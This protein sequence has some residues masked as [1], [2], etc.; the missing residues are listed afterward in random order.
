MD[1]IKFHTCV[2]I[3]GPYYRVSKTSPRFGLQFLLWTCLVACKLCFYEVYTSRM[4]FC[5]HF[6]SEHVKLRSSSYSF[7]FFLKILY[8]PCT[9]LK[10]TQ[11][12]LLGALLFL[13]N[14]F[15]HILSYHSCFLNQNV[16]KF[17]LKKRGRKGVGVSTI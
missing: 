13:N 15:T 6:F 12:M 5:P 16:L 14:S 9:C 4:R 7:R 3:S 10:W 1:K 8:Y 17:F 11:Q 2:F